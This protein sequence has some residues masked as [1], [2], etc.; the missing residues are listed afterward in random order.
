MP[1]ARIAGLGSL[2]TGSTQELEI[3]K[4]QSTQR[5]SRVHGERVS[6]SRTFS[7]NLITDSPFQKDGLGGRAKVRA[8][9]ALPAKDVRYR[10]KLLAASGTATNVTRNV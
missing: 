3:A 7:V 5:A 10:D 9:L 1:F 6:Q 8:G 4:E 2:R